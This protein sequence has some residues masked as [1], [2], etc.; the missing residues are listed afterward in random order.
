VNVPADLDGAVDKE[1]AQAGDGGRGLLE[2]VQR[3]RAVE[4]SG[5]VH[6]LLQVLNRQLAERRRRR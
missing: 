6:V 1:L 5:S 2:V 3:H 4:A